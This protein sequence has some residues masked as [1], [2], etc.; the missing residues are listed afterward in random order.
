MTN[1]QNYSGSILRGDLDQW[2]F[3]ANQGD[4]VWVSVSEV[5]QNTAFFPQIDLIGPDGSNKGVDW[6]DLSAG[7]HITSTLSGTYTVVISRRDGSDGVG[8]YSLTLAK[9]PAAFVVPQGDEGGPMLSGEN[10]A[11][12]ILR[13]DL[14]QWTF[15]ATQGANITIGVS[16][17]GANTPFFPEISVIAPDGRNVG[18]NWGDRTAQIQLQAAAGAY[19]VIVSRRDN[20]DGIGNY[21]LSVLTIPTASPAFYYLGLAAAPDGGGFITASPASASGYYQGG[22]RVCLTASP[23]AGYI[24]TSWSGASL[25]GSHCLTVNQNQS[26]AANFA[27]LKSLRFVAVAPC[28]L[29]DTRYPLD[30]F[31]GPALSAGSTRDFVIPDA[32][33]CNIPYT[34][35]AYSLNVTVVPH[36]HLNYLTVWPTGQPQPAVSTLNSADGRIKANAAI[37]PA[38]TDGGVSVFATDPTDVILDINGYFVPSSTPSSLGFFPVAPCRIADTRSG[39]GAFGEPAILAGHPRTFPVLSSACRLRLVRRLIR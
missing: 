9:S 21:S 28:R 30:P 13:G 33:V 2:S 27:A 14:D 19:K 31:G 25:D 16:E 5:G 1:G 24:F 18:V 22:T 10:H 3:T 23:A 39:S 12:I 26:V 36:A 37:I 32:S 8:Q 17:T 34:A 38:G 15:Y 11:G 20:A 6:G 4:D 29:A 7:I 35:E